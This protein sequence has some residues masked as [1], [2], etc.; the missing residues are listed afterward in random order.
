[1]SESEL[2]LN[3]FYN[4][5]KKLIAYPVSVKG[6]FSHYVKQTDY[7]ELKKYNTKPENLPLRN[8]EEFIKDMIY[9]LMEY[10][11]NDF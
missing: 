8:Y 3:E 4:E 10:K 5:Q 11:E 6:L 1:M 7:A 9:K 2:E